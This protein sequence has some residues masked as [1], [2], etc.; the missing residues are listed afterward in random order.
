ML[1]ICVCNKKENY[2]FIDNVTKKFH[3]NTIIVNYNFSSNKV[4]VKII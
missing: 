1:G 2:P 4:V 3:S